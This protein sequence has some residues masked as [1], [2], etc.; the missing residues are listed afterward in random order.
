MS[1]PCGIRSSDFGNHVRMPSDSSS[2]LLLH[3]VFS[4]IHGFQ[5]TTPVTCDVV[6]PLQPGVVSDEDDPVVSHNQKT[7]R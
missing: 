7:K 4:L 6:V 2:E 5:N 3:K 1:G